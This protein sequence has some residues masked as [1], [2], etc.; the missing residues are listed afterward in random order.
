MHT[1]LLISE[2]ILK[3]KYETIF[4]FIK[5]NKR[6]KFSIGQIHQVQLYGVNHLLLRRAYVCLGLFSIQ[7]PLLLWNFWIFKKKF[8]TKFNDLNVY[9]CDKGWNKNK[10]VLHYQPTSSD[11]L[12]SNGQLAFFLWEFKCSPIGLSTLDGK[13]FFFLCFMS[14]NMSPRVETFPQCKGHTWLS[15][16]LKPLI[17]GLPSSWDFSFHYEISYVY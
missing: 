16:C 14:G 6:L 8:K 15:L 2:P 9:E 7:R 5:F 11:Q 4:N 10:F 17:F 13:A 3:L 12:A 1:S